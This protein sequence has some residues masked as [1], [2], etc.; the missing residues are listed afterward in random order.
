MTD[1]RLKGEGLKAPAL[2]AVNT[3]TVLLPVNIVKLQSP[4]FPRA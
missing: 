4:A 3:D 2:G 1:T